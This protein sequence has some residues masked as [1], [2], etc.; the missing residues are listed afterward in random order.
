[1]RKTPEDAS[2]EQKTTLETRA[3]SRRLVLGGAAM[4]GMGAICL[5]ATRAAAQ[6]KQKQADVQ[7][8]SSP[9]DGQ[10]CSGCALFQPPNA[11]AGVEG[12]ISPEG[13]CSIFSPKA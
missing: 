1:M 13:W 4:A 6:S 5:T 12:E 3:V 10:K 9:K 2:K 7:Y 11:C 8:Q